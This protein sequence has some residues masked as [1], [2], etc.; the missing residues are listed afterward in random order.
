[1]PHVADWKKE[2]VAELE[3]LTNNNE[4]IGIVN[5][6]DIPAPQLQTMRR[7][8]GDKAILKCHVKTSLKLL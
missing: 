2:K 1:M 7:T 3:E 8:L 6:A 5:L 4:I